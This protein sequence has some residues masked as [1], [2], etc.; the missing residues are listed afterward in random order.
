M[1]ADPIRHAGLAPAQPR[2]G[3]PALGPEEAAP[4]EG[5]ATFD[6]VLSALNPLHH[7]PGVGILYRA[8]TGERIQPA[9]RVLGAAIFGGVPGML[10]TAALAAVEETRP[11]ERLALALTGAPDPVLD[12]PARDRALTAYR[13]HGDAG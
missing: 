6:E 10:L 11:M 2:D 13:Q 5:H 3:G 8:V 1:I 12:P 9:F 7:L 4:I